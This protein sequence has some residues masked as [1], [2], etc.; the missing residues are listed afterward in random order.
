MMLILITVSFTLM[1]H[2]AATAV[3]ESLH[4]PPSPWSTRT[5][6]RYRRAI[7]SF[8]AAFHAPGDGDAGVAGMDAGR[9]T[10]R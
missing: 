4:T 7:V 2:T 5:A 3:P 6:R 9:Y 1:I 10:S 8:S